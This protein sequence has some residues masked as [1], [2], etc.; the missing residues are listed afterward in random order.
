MKN[1]ETCGAPTNTQGL[2][3]AFCQMFA[4]ARAKTEMAQ[5]FTFGDLGVVGGG[6]LEPAKWLSVGLSCIEL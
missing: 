3:A 6:K 5:R 4:K 1:K 2:Q